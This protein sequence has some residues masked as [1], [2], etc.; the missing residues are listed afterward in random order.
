[1]IIDYYFIKFL[2]PIFHVIDEKKQHLKSKSMSNI[3]LDSLAPQIDIPLGP[4][5][6]PKL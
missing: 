5:H 3:E 2:P 4:H 1:M 6:D